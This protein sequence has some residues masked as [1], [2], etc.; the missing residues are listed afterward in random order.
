VKS[1]LVSLGLVLLSAGGLR[2]DLQAAKAEPNLE[3]RSKLALDNALQALQDARAAYAQGEDAR[4][5]ALAKE[6]LESVELAETSLRETGK[7]ARKSPKWFKRAEI[8][9]RD[10]M[11]R[12]DAFQREMN[13]A[14]RPRLDA[15]KAKVQQVHE[16]LLFGIMGGKEK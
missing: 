2:A 1:V 10:L 14:D 15:V 5:D 8:E 6:I 16:N 9:T 13:V 3:K 4:L 7:N 12:L 11:R